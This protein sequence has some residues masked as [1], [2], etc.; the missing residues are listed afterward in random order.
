MSLNSLNIMIVEILVCLALAAL[1]GLLVGWFIQRAIAKRAAA[2]ASAEAK[3]R[4]QAL[5]ESS[6]QEVNNLEDQIQEL[7]TELRSVQ[8]NN[9]NLNN[10]LQDSKSS[11]EKAHSESVEITQ[12]QLQTNERLQ[13]IIREKDLEI[14]RLMNAKPSGNT[15]LAAAAASMGA[16]AGLVKQISNPKAS[17]TQD[18]ADDTL[19]ATTVLQSP[20]EAVQPE[21]ISDKQTANA[22]AA[23]NASTDQLKG[24]RQAL[25]DA[26]SEG[27]ETIAIDHRDLPIDLRQNL[28]SSDTDKTIALDKL[29]KTIQSPFD[30]LDDTEMSDTQETP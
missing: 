23:L 25:L 4:Y 13:S 15:N 19:D 2:K 3:A 5:E 10:S 8:S 14:S 7:G 22:V 16:S 28:S 1:L 6:R 18:M 9:Q 30:D 12:A 21:D 20:V 29:D 27:E 17:D 24:E 11:I 26:L